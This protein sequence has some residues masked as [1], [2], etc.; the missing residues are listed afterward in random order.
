[1][2]AFPTA[3]TLP[4][5]PSENHNANKKGTNDEDPI[6]IPEITPVSF[7]NFLSMFYNRWVA[8]FS[9]T[10]NKFC[11]NTMLVQQAK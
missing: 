3:Q 8:Y 5:E 6:F 7:E 4:D 10:W 9:S 11:P 2:F 1:M